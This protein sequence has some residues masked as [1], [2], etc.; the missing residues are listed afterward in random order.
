MTL[1]SSTPSRDVGAVSGAIAKLEPGA[2]VGL[3]GPFGTSWPVAA[4]EGADVVLVAGGLGLAPLRPAIY[5]IL[6]NRGR[7]G[8]VII[9][10]RQPQSRPTCFIATNWRNGG[11]AST[12]RSK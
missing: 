8:R 7:Y 12:S 9:L 5:E 2:T 1:F 6:A 3:R 10:V 4:A 11:G